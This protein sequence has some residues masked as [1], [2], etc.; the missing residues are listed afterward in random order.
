M[1]A[2][3]P[4]IVDWIDESGK[5]LQ[6]LPRAEIRRRNLLHRV[7][8]T[9]VFHPDNRVFVH[10]RSA[11]KDVYPSLYDMFVGGT[12][13][14][15]ESYEAN[16]CREL[17]E[18]LGVSGTPIYSLFGHSFRDEVSRS[19]TRVFACVSEGPFRFPPEEVV[20]GDWRDT[21]HVNGMVAEGRIARPSAQSGRRPG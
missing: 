9:L 15:G 7:S 8:S 16:A 6:S 10:R 18:E 14:S 21:G 20:W 2:P 19:L 17:E 1:S 11:E 4:E 13:V 3:P 5:T 12:V